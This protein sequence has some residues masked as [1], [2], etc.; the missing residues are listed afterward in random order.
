MVDDPT[1]Q[2]SETAAGSGEFEA[3]VK[4]QANLVAGANERWDIG[5]FIALDGGDARTGECA[6][7]FLPSF[8]FPFNPKQNYKPPL[9]FGLNFSTLNFQLLLSLLF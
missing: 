9:H 4:F 8:Q 6:R 3:S 1:A 2:C 5:M 7:N